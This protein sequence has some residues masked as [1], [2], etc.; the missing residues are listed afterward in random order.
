MNNILKLGKDCCGC[1]GC[2]QACPQHCITFQPDSEGFAYPQVDETKCT[3]CGVCIKKCPIL[4]EAPRAAAPQVFAAKIKDAPTAFRSTSGGVFM[5]IA[6]HVLQQNGVVF[7][8]AYDENLRAVHI[9]AENEEQLQ[10]LQSS[11]YVQSDTR[12][13]YA[14]AKQALDSGRTVLFSGTGCQTAG[15][16]TFLG[17]DYPNLLLTDIVCHGV[18][19]PLLFRRYLEYKGGQ[20]GGT[21]TGYNFRSKEKRGWD[22][23]YKAQTDKKS[24]SDYGFFDPYYNAFLT[25][26][27]YRESCYKCPFANGERTG[28]ITLADYWGIQKFHPD[29]YDSNGVSLILV[30]TEKGAALWKTLRDQIESIPSTMEKARVMNKNLSVPSERPAC[31][32]GIYEGIEGDLQRYFTEKLAFSVSPK[33]KI[34]QMIPPGLK[35]AVKKI[36]S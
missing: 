33:M 29:F 9:A 28:D 5:V 34:K 36:K 19:S 21:I 4:T 20:M 18:P 3:G 26:K 15:L 22:L 14:Q 2:E 24:K 23:Y 1:A 7:G 6:R 12:G 16:R 10:R 35:R 13:I 27:T 17:R 25:C 11:K 31:R 32:D 30:N 8:C